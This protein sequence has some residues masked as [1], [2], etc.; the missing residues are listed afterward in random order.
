MST[1][2]LEYKGGSVFRL[3]HLLKG[4]QP[5]CLT[6]R[7][8]F[9]DATMLPSTSVPTLLLNHRNFVIPTLLTSFVLFDMLLARLGFT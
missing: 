1:V 4:I 7:A 5:F 6:T 3:G 8:S 2:S 9:V